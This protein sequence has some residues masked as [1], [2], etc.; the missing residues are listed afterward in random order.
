M[1]EDIN[2]HDQTDSFS[3][4]IFGPECQKQVLAEDILADVDGSQVFDENVH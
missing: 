2:G 4:I 3:M 1:K